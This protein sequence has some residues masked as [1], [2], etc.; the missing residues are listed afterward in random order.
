VLVAT[1]GSLPQGGVTLPSDDIAF[2]P[3]TTMAAAIRSK[4]LSP[5]EV[6]DAILSRI[7]GL[8]P[9][10]NAYLTVDADAAIQAARAAEQAAADG[11]ELGALHGVP[12]SVKDLTCTRGLRTTLGSLLYRDNVPDHDAGAVERL[13]GAG[14]I[15]LGKTNTPEFGLLG[16]TENRLGDPC[17]NPWNPER[18]SGGSSGGAAS[19]VAAGLGPLALGSDGGGSVRI[20]SAFCGVF[21]LKPT[22]GRVP[23]HRDVCGWGTLSVTGPIARTVADAALMLDVM[24]GSHPEDPYSLPPPR[25]S[26]REAVQGDL[27][28]LRAAWSPDLGYGAVELEVRRTAEAAA[29][30]FADLGCAVEEDDPGIDDP[31]AT[32]TFVDIAAAYTAAELE[33]VSTE[34]EGLL[35]EY[36]VSFRDYGRRVSGVQLVRADRSR[37]AMWRRLR[38]FFQRYDL[39]LTPTLAVPA[40][41]IGR[42]PQVIDGRRVVPFGWSPFTPSFN[43]SGQP[44]ANVPCGW[45]ADGLPLGLQIVGRPF[46]E[47]TVLRAAAAFEAAQPWQERH[48][49]LA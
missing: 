37:L 46:E 43:L 48:P 5:V 34:Q 3:A 49:P 23:H 11:D 19:A 14:A 4:K 26:F 13:R 32:G 2:M 20:P 15:I 27:K 25:Y 21:G 6:L 44:A 42:E 36:A 18:T 28:G 31:I 47:A 24:A 1:P 30:R 40:F 41:P 12:V 33:D 17:R 45:S 8:N 7:E 38:D 22:F 16:T 9:R 39:L 35:T 10:L 29:H